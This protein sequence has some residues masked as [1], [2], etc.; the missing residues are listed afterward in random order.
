MLLFSGNIGNMSTVTQVTNNGGA[1]MYKLCGGT[2][3]VLLVNSSKDKVSESSLLADLLKI[4]D[5]TLRKRA[6]F[7]K[8]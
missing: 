2:L 4:L 3:L 5:P 1:F 7:K 8:G 6:G